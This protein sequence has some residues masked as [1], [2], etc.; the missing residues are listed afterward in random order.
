MCLDKF[1]GEMGFTHLSSS[2][3]FSSVVV[4]AYFVCE[5][6]I[7]LWELSWMVTNSQPFSAWL[8]KD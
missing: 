6:H 4:S 3:H 1:M 5:T 2:L 7:I 8:A